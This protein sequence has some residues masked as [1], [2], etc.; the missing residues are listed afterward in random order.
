MIRNALIGRR[1]GLKC[2]I[3][4]ESNPKTLNAFLFP[5]FDGQFSKAYKAIYWRASDNHNDRL[6]F[7]VHSAW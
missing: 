7:Y 5:D 1:L 2:E 6:H 4:V 3:S